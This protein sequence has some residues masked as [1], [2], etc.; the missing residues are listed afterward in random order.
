MLLDILTVSRL[1][2]VWFPP[3][4]ALGMIWEYVSLQ[5]DLQSAYVRDTL[6]FRNRIRDG[7]NE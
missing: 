4:S 3:S 5:S 6:S 1:V 2:A 7:I